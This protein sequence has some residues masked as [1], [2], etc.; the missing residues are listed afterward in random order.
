M[1]QKAQHTLLQVLDIAAREGDTDLVDFGGGDGGAGSV[2]L[3]FTLGDVAHP[4]YLLESQMVTVRRK[5][6]SARC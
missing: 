1:Q 2:V 5:M 4:G 3:L 6:R